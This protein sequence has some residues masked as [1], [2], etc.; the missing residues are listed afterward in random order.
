MHQKLS[1]THSCMCNAVEVIEDFVSERA[2]LKSELKSSSLKIENLINDVLTAS[3]NL[4]C[5][6]TLRHIEW[7]AKVYLTIRA[8]R[9]VKLA[10]DR[11]E[12]Q[13]AR[14][15]LSLRQSL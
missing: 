1:E 12:T 4:P 13:G 8:Y 5:I 7:F 9:V 10:E 3:I 6:V 2:P 15:H 11:Q 14:P